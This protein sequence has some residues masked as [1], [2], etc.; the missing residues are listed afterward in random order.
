MFGNRSLR[1]YWMVIGHMLIFLTSGQARRS[2]TMDDPGEFPGDV[3]FALEGGGLAAQQINFGASVP[4]IVDSFGLANA[5]EFFSRIER[6]RN[7]INKPLDVEIEQVGSPALTIRVIIAPN[8][9]DR[10]GFR[11]KPGALREGED[12]EEIL[13]LNL[14]D[15]NKI[16]AVAG[17]GGMGDDG[18]GMPVI[19][20]GAARERLN[21]AHGGKGGSVTIECDSRNTVFAFGGDGGL[22]GDAGTGGTASG[23]FGAGGRGGSADVR[24]EDCNNIR[25]QGG[26]GGRRGTQGVFPPPVPAEGGPGGGAA[27]LS[28]IPPNVG[29]VEA[30][31]G[32]QGGLDGDALNNAAGITTLTPRLGP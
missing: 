26:D 21:G 29:T 25:C 3:R 5:A 7:L 8:G 6:V 31:K 11:P 22:G 24:F 10:K 32:V 17:N 20:E 23:N 19:P 27:V 28:T 14:G 4:K 1:I 15:D 16:I 2:P 30:G 18:E 13:L 9:R 12:G